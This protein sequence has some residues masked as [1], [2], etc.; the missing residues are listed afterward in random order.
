MFK[1]YTFFFNMINLH[2]QMNYAIAI[3]VSTQA[4][5]ANVTCRWFKEGTS[6]VNLEKTSTVTGQT[7]RTDLATQQESSG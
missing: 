3:F 4:Y 7:T 5:T 1:L 2:L 6:S